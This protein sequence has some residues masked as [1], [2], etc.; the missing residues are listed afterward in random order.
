MKISKEFKVGLLGVISLTLFYFGFNFLKG[1]D[2][3]SSTNQYYAIYSEVDGLQVSNQVIINGLM[4][5]RVNEIK[6]MPGSENEIIV[7]MDVNSDIVLGESTVALLKNA[8]FLGMSKHIELSPPESIIKYAQDGD[9]LIGQI[10]R[11][12]TDVLLESA[13]PVATDLGSTI[14]RVNLILESVAGNTGKI[15]NTLSNFEQTSL[16]MKETFQENRKDLNILISNLNAISIQFAATMEQMDPIL[17]NTNQ[18]VDSLN[19]LPLKETLMETRI[20]IDQLSEA[21]EKVNQG[22]GTV[23]KFINDDSVYVNLNQSLQDLD[24]LLIDL[25]ENPNRYVHFSLFGRKN[26]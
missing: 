13:G 5:G 2:F 18:F 22:Q 26:N 12:I 4:V 21:I 24:Q 6:L 11:G 19:S 10:D 17:N 8:N 9:T 14:R 16:I 15:D 23:A 3:F 20:A 7:Q 1:I 25:R